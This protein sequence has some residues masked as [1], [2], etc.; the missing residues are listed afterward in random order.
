MSK[1]TTDNDNHF[2]EPLCILGTKVF[3]NG[4]VSVHNGESVLVTSPIVDPLG[5]E[6]TVIGNL[7]QVMPIDFTIS[8]A[9]SSSYHI[10]NYF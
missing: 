8:L 5:K 2:R 9:T 7:A 4:E 6:K 1:F 3:R 10:L